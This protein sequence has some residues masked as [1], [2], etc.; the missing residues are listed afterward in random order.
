MS[1]LKNINNMNKGTKIKIIPYRPL[2]MGI[3]LNII[4]I[5]DHN[6]KKIRK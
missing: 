4:L 3:L 6:T 2:K 5:I 1:K